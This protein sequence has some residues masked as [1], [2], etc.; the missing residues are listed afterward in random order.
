MRSALALALCCTAPAQVAIL[1]IQITQ[2][3]GAVHA[4]GARTPHP[5][6]VTVTDETGRP[7]EGAAVSFHVPEE[8][9]GGT[10]ANGMRTEV[11]STDG[12]GRATVSMLQVNRVS[13][14]FQIRII[15]SKE[16][17]RAGVISSQYVAEANSGAA[18]PAGTT[19][20]RSKRRKWMM[21]A[22]VAAG[23]ALAGILA[24][25]RSGSRNSPAPETPAPSIGTPTI[26]VGKP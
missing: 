3:D 21:G 20:M 16:Q 23:G 1:Q 11:Q 9:P 15:A 8:G 13:G 19:V 4:P 2:G 17:A 14:R 5:L 25:G 26:T 6:T 7:V 10:F 12:Q 18:R 24:S 22:A